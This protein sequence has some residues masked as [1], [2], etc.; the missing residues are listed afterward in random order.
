MRKFNRPMLFLV[1][2][3]HWAAVLPDQARAKALVLQVATGFMAAQLADCDRADQFP[4]LPKQRLAG[5]VSL[6]CHHGNQCQRMHE[7]SSLRGG[8]R[9]RLSLYRGLS[10][11]AAYWSTT[12]KSL[13]LRRFK[14]VVKLI[15]YVVSRS[16]KMAFQPGAEL[17]AVTTPLP[18]VVFSHGLGGNRYAYS[19]LCSNLAAQGY[20]VYAIEHAD[21]S[22]S[23][24]KLAGNGAS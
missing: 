8:F 22:S 18:V 19:I 7:C 9:G 15:C 4:F 21:G 2:A 11:D 6:D 1:T 20:V 17:I 24:C 3:H 13:L 16:Q 23:G 12:C 10:A 5:P 14:F